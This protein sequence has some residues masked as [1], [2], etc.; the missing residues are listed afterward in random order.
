MKRIA[1]KTDSIKNCVKAE[2]CVWSTKGDGYTFNTKMMQHNASTTD[3]MKQNVKIELGCWSGKTDAHSVAWIPICKCLKMFQILNY[4]RQHICHECS[5]DSIVFGVCVQQQFLHVVT[6]LCS[7]QARHAF[8]FNNWCSFF[9]LFFCA[10][11]QQPLVEPKAP[12]LRHLMPASSL[13]AS[14]QPTK[15]KKNLIGI[16]KKNTKC[17]G[18][19]SNTICNNTTKTNTRTH[20]HTTQK[21]IESI[22]TQQASKNLNPS[23]H[24][25]R[26]ASRPSKPS[27]QQ[28]HQPPNRHTAT[29]TTTTTTITTPSQQPQTW[30]PPS[31][32]IPRQ[33]TRQQQHV[34]DTCFPLAA[35]N[36]TN[37]FFSE[38]LGRKEQSLNAASGTERT[39]SKRRIWN[40]KNEV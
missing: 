29:T 27:Q 11:V 9:M 28:S 15:K 32:T 5:V 4:W 25:N 34:F 35:T 23:T 33:H 36:G 38:E 17:S 12:C 21:N 30:P 20:T 10:C 31:K 1:S 40:G 18:Q 39:K 2:L 24:D 26:I 19:A 8:S 3:C 37:G 16:S 22:H 6:L 7:G 14:P 13:E